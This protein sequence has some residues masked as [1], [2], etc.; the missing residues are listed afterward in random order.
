M[1]EASF[2]NSSLAGVIRW[3]TT[4]RGVLP[5][6]TSVALSSGNWEALSM[7]KVSGQP[8]MW[9]GHR[10]IWPQGSQILACG[11]DW[12]EKVGKIWT[13]NELLISQM[14]A[15][16]RTILRSVCN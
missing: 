16:Q 13:C 12:S 5:P 4:G 6:G 7:G 9:M 3:S 1:R 10:T 8:G 14:Y 11:Q 2:E 15:L